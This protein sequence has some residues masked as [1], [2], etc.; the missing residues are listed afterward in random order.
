MLI[1]IKDNIHDYKNFLIGFDIKG[2]I[3]KFYKY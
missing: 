3:L 1:S 2:Y